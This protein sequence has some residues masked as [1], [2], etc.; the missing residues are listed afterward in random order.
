[1]EPHNTSIIDFIKRNVLLVSLFSLASVFLGIGTIQLFAQ[2]DQSEEMEFVPAQEQNEQMSEIFVNVSGEVEK[3]GVYKLSSNSRFQDA[4]VAAGGLSA[5]ADRVYVDKTLNLAA[6][7]TDGMKIYIPSSGEV[8]SQAIN[9]NSESV[10]GASS[11]GV[12]NIN[13]ASSSQL[14][15]LPKIG[16]A[17]AQKIIDGRPYGSVDE[18]LNKKVLGQATYEAIK[19]LVTAF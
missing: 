4:I 12:V 2:K 8:S 6:K 11:E 17:T 14:E 19:D 9:T 3:P 18:L 1:M 5:D 7:I 13:N 10:A 16:P 15:N